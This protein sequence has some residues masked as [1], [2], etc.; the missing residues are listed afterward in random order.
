MM[1]TV[2]DDTFFVLRQAAS[3]SLSTATM[4]CFVST[5][6]LAIAQLT[7]PFRDTLARSLPPCPGAV[8]RLFAEGATPTAADVEA[9]AAPLNNVVACTTYATK[10][11]AALEPQ[12]AQRC[13]VDSCLWSAPERLWH[14]VHD[15]SHVH[16]GGRRASSGPQP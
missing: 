16:C 1:T 12:A 4:H 10:M 2:V 6:S 9:A 3:R 5:L 13:G 11:H 7:G 15:A 14:A 8:V